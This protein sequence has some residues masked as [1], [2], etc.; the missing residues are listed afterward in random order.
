MESFTCNTT[1]TRLRVKKGDVIG[2]C[3][4][5]TDGL[6]FLDEGSPGHSVYAVANSN[7]CS[8]PK[9]IDFSPTSS[10]V[11][12]MN[13]T[14]FHVTAEIR[15]DSELISISKK[16]A[17]PESNVN[18]GPNRPTSAVAG[19]VS[20]VILAIAV[21]S[22]GVM[23][24][25]VC[26]LCHKAAPSSDL[27][28]SQAVRQNEYGDNKIDDTKSNVKSKVE[29]LEYEIALNSIETNCSSIATESK[30]NTFTCTH[31]KKSAKSLESYYSTPTL[32][33]MEKAQ[34]HTSCHSED[35]MP[36]YVPASDEENLCLQLEKQGIKLIPSDEIVYAS[37]LGSGQFGTVNKATWTWAKRDNRM[38]LYG[39]VTTGELMLVVEYISQ[40]D[41]K[42]YLMSMNTNMHRAGFQ[43]T[44]RLLLSFAQQ[45]AL[46]MN[47][48]AR[49]GFVHRDLAARNVL[50]SE[51]NVCKIADFGLSRDLE[52]QNCYISHGGKVPVK[53][54]APEAI[55]FN[56]YSTASDV[57]SYGC[58]LYELWS[59]GDIPFSGFENRKVVEVLKTGYRLSPPTG[60]PRAI[61]EQMMKCW[62]PEPDSRPTFTMILLSLLEYE[63]HIR[64]V[65]NDEDIIHKHK[66]APSSSENEYLELQQWYVNEK[67][68]TD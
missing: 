57:W 41:L 44:N 53:W 23:L 33:A 6:Y 14:A 34:K 18:I 27:E 45:I 5:H 49:K 68:S 24:V 17:I 30:R 7:Q 46:G 56:K 12:L 26:M 59:L 39:L 50:V 20:A 29:A 1:A 63:K 9:R 43:V 51:R 61:Y 31:D 19:I 55:C 11:H 15:L 4:A 21:T 16:T 40:G 25:A 2:A 66:D 37:F 67:G 58:V 38:T 36:Y 32:L 35:Q 42:T 64:E 65:Q 8:L 54:T 3:I 22:I 28:K 47:Y 60:C 48:L 52:D 13:G 62:H 10:D